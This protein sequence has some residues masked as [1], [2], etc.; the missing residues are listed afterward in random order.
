MYE[1]YFSD[2]R[3]AAGGVSDKM[4]I[5]TYG[6]NIYVGKLLP[7]SQESWGFRIRCKYEHMCTMFFYGNFSLDLRRAGSPATQCT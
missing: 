7:T 5:W 4:Y 1:K 2:H 3:T 6:N